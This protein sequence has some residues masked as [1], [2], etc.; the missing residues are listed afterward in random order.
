MISYRFYGIRGDPGKRIA[1][2]YIEP[3]QDSSALDWSCLTVMVPYKVKL[4]QGKF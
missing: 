1:G 3:A 4:E 2:V